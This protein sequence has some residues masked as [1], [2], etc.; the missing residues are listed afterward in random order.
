MKLSI[1]RRV[2]IFG[3]AVVAAAGLTAASMAQ[4]KPVLKFSA[5]FSDT[6]IR[7]D[8]MRM[9]G[10][11]L[12]GDFTFEPHFGGRVLAKADNARNARLPGRRLTSPTSPKAWAG[13]P[14]GRSK[15]RRKSARR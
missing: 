6:D 5:V 12:A 11:A 4:D 7:A 14:K 10:E 8:A 3:C 13:T 1:N 9:L 15:I 2:A